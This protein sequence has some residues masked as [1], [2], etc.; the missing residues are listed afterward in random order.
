M[1]TV[2]LI[3]QTSQLSPSLLLL[4]FQTT[5]YVI[6][7][8]LFAAFAHIYIYILHTYFCIDRYE[9]FI[10]M[11]SYWYVYTVCPDTDSFL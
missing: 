10:I 6:D 5:M 7:Y 9:W 2:P 8:Q 3:I 11:M 1:C 4:S